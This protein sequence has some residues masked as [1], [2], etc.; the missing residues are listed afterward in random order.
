MWCI[1]LSID[2]IIC[3]QGCGDTPARTST[4]A[5]PLTSGGKQGKAAHSAKEEKIQAPRRCTLTLT[6]SS[7]FFFNPPAHNNMA[8]LGS[9]AERPTPTLFE[10]AAPRIIQTL[11]CK[12][13]SPWW[14]VWVCKT[15]Q[16]CNENALSYRYL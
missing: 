5:Q 1:N 8:V 6:L 10:Y 9:A 14:L 16:L 2:Q 15:Y 11:D 4:L 3:C 13:N 12:A 7:D